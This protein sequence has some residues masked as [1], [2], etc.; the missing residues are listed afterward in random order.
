MLEVKDLQKSYDNFNI[1]VDFTIAKGE[2]FSLLGPSGCGKTTTLRLIAG[3]EDCDSGSIKLSGLDITKLPPQKRNL[4]LVFQDYALFPHLSVTE[5]ILYGLRKEKREIKERR[6]KDLL[7]LFK[8]EDLKDRSVRR[9]SGGESQRVALAR[10]L[11]VEPNLLLLDEPFAAL[12]PALRQSLREEL[13]ELQ[14]TLGLTIVFVTHNQEE[15]LSL[16]DR[17]ALLENGRIVQMGT[18]FEIYTQPNSP[19]VASFFGQVNLVQ[20]E[21]KKGQIIF[22]STT[23]PL[24]VADGIYQFAIRPEHLQIGGGVRGRIIKRSY[25][26][27]AV[28]YLV[29]TNLGEL[30]YLDF[31]PNSLRENGSEIELS[32]RKALLV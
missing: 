1:A 9:L 30:R 20:L 18:P 15:A 21:V 28:E 3:L 2:F 25:L 11:A 19:Y 23:L 22:G 5:N 14:K 24:E 6:L 27:F 7:A 26:G 13:K 17:I 10:A 4:G 12:D 8:L 32:L 31:N 29:A 16:S